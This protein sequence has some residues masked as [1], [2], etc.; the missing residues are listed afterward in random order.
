M[1]Q[2]FLFMLFKHVEHIV[3]LRATIYQA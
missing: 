2:P 3:Y 1:I